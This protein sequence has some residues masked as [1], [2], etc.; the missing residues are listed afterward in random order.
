MFPPGPPSLRV[1][2]AY[3]RPQRFA[4]RMTWRASL[5]ISGS[6]IPPGSIGGRRIYQARKG[7]IT[8]KDGTILGFY[9]REQ[10]YTGPEQD[11]HKILIRTWHQE[12]SGL[13]GTACWQVT[14][15]PLRVRLGRLFP[16]RAR[17]FL[18]QG[19]D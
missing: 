6:K 10:E 3:L 5:E 1:F 7:V 14:E 13:D 15:L 2:R 16:Y 8:A 4:Y 11:Q 9:D 12:I 18:D 17:N 19:L